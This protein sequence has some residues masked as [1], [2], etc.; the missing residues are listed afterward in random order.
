MQTW[1]TFALVILAALYFFRSS[2]KSALGKGCASGCGSCG[3]AGCPAKKLQNTLEQG[4]H[5]R[6]GPS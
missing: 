1:I 5:G 6:P 3:S 2:L 4:P